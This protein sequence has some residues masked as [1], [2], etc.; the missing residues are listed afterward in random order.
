[1]Q[2]SEQ[3]FWPEGGGDADVRIR[4]LEGPQTRVGRV[5]VRGAGETRQGVLRRFVDLEP[6]EP[7]SRPELLE[8]ERELSRLGIFSRVDVDLAPG[9]LGRQERDVVVRY[10]EGRS[11]R[12][13]YGVGYDTDDGARGLVGF[14]HRNL[15]GRAWSAQV[16]ARVSERD[17]RYRLL[18]GQPYLGRWDVPV[19]YSLFRF[20]EDRESFNQQSFGAR[21]E[22]YRELRQGRFGLVYDYRIIDL[23]EVEIP[24]N[25]IERQDREIEVSSLIPNLFLDRRDDPFDP[26]QG[27]SSALQLQYAFPAFDTDAHFL[28]LFVQ[29]TGY[30]DLDGPG[31][32]AGS[33]RL[34]AIEPLESEPPESE[35]AN[36]IPIGERFFAGGRTSHRGFERDGLGVRG[37]TLLSPLEDPVPVGGNGLLLANLEY[38]FRLVGALGGT[39][40]LDVGNVW[41]DWQEVDLSEV[42]TAIGLGVRYRSPVGP[43]RLEVGWKLDREPGESA[44]ELFINLGNPF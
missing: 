16:D 14:A 24:L 42:R 1:M 2:I 35:V 40:F 13:S 21:V 43:I 7:V 33:L 31:V 22:G 6:G 9:E 34:G 3:V 11:K 32:L 39:L 37:E 27:W 26:T 25:E 8:V 15:W 29:Q 44:A 19:T 36:P 23:T 4:V 18:L 30:L 5:L 17:Q 12:V 41:S 38:R 20:D 10:E 28:K